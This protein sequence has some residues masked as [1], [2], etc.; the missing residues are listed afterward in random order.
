MVVTGLLTAVMPT[1][2]YAQGVYGQGVYGQ[3]PNLQGLFVP[4]AATRVALP[5]IPVPP[6][7][8]PRDVAPLDREMWAGVSYREALAGLVVLGGSAVLVTW[9]SGSAIA[10]MTAAASL[11]AAYVVYDPEVTGVL[12]PSDIPSLSDGPLAGSKSDE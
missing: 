4:V 11:A 1:V 12:A 3:G 9:L 10:G 2:G 5:P 7:M 6:I 8:A